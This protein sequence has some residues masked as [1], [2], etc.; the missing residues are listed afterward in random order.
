MEGNGRVE[1]E[2]ERETKGGGEELEETGNRMTMVEEGQ[3]ERKRKEK[4]KEIL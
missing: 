4:L 1:K 2:E 3:R